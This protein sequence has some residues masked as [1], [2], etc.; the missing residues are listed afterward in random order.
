MET[1]NK[2]Y[3]MVNI[4]RM[5][6]ALLVIVI[7]TM[8]FNQFGNAAKYIT[9]DV[10]ARIAVPFFFIT[11]GFFLYSKINQEGYIKKYIK[12]LFLVYLIITAIS[13][14]LLFPLIMNTIY[15]QCNGVADVFILFA[16][17]L[18]VN[19]F[20]GAL[21]YF[22]ALIFSTIFVSVFLKKNWIKPLIGFAI[23]FFV[24]GLMGDSYQT[25]VA[26]TPLMKIV[27]IYNVAFDLTRNGFCIGVPFI[28]IGALINKFN[29]KDR[30]NHV[31]RLILIFSAVYGL[32]AYLVISKDLF[33]DTNIYITLA[34]IVPLIF[35]WALNSKV[36]I[37]DRTSNLFKEMSLWVYGFH[38]LI[39]L[40]ALAYLKVNPKA[41]FFFYLMVVCITIFIAYIISCK[42]LKEPVENKKSERKIPIAC[43]VIGC[44]ILACFLAFK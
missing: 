6:C 41:T 43:L 4:M 32:E 16:K 8:A 18:L 3:P 21:W 12:K 7:H 44:A 42:R 39:Q 15:T 11:S 25:L 19:G 36:S 22:P 17:I 2:K 38:Q 30:I 14:V 35:I 27:D 31:G 40:A 37:S 10:I 33:R 9:S 5:V 24:I 29:L 23:L 26:N 34:F 28:V 20:P 1:E 13:A